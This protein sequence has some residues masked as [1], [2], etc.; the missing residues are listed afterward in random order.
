MA[1]GAWFD[2]ALASNEPERHGNPNVLTRDIGTSRLTQGTSALSALVEIE[3]WN[4]AVPPVGV[5]TAPEI[6]HAEPAEA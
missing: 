1:T 3:R 5:W 2:P 4:G 6:V